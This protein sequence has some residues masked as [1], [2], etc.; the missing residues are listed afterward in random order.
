[1]GI[2][3][4]MT[5]DIQSDVAY[6]RSVESGS[7]KTGR[8]LGSFRS[9]MRASVQYTVQWNDRINEAIEEW[10]FMNGR[11]SMQE[12]LRTLYLQSAGEPVFL[13]HPSGSHKGSFRVLPDEDQM[14]ELTP[15]NRGEFIRGRL[16]A[17]LGVSSV[18]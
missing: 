18:Y 13:T 14:A 9:P 3:E 4:R 8:P 2:P 16:A 7:A 17:A 6:L 10:R 12:T 15:G 1:M 11:P 5:N